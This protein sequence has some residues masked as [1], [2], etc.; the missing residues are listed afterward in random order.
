MCQ[1][2]AVRFEWLKVKRLQPWVEG[3]FWVIR[4]REPCPPRGPRCE[5]PSPGGPWGVQSER[6]TVHY[7]LE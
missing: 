3:R 7:A 5:R 1:A 4:P 2:S 6:T